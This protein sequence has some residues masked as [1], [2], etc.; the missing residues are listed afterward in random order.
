MEVKFKVSY[1]MSRECLREGWFDGGGS[2]GQGGKASQ[3]EGRV[4]AKGL[5]GG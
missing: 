1:F 5:A 2:V 3:A 4:N